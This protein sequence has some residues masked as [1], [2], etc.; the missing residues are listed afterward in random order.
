MRVDSGNTL[1]LRRS[2][3]IVSCSNHWSEYMPFGNSLTNCI[4]WHMPAGSKQVHS[5][6]ADSNNDVDDG[7]PQPL[8]FQLPK[9][10]EPPQQER[11]F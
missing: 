5:K 4:C 3:P 6:Q 10:P 1:A 8:K 11:A 7:S 2:M 9:T